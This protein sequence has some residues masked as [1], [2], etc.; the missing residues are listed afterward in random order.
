MQN[1]TRTIGSN[2]GFFSAADHL[3]A[4]GISCALVFWRVLSV[5]EQHFGR[6]PVAHSS[7][8]KLSSRLASG[9]GGIGSRLRRISTSVVV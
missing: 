1:V 4:L 9:A 3:A 6:P 7:S 2:S 5:L 8:T